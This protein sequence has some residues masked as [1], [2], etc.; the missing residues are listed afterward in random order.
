MSWAVGVVV[1]SLAIALPA[2]SL[3]ASGRGPS[4]VRTAGRPPGGVAT[5]TTS[6]ETSTSVTATTTIVARSTAGRPTTTTSLVCRDSIDPRC[7]PFYWDPAPALF[8]P[9]TVHVS[10][11]PTNPRPGEVVTFSFT[12]DDPV[13]PYIWG[14]YCGHD[15]GDQTVDPGN[16]CRGSALPGPPPPEPHGPWTPPPPM[17]G[18]CPASNNDNRVFPA[19]GC[20]F[21]PGGV[22][23]GVPNP[24][25]AYS[26]AGTY[27]ASF[28]FHA[29]GLPAPGS[30]NRSVAGLPD[31]YADTDS[32]TVA[33]TVSGPPVT[34]TSTSTS[35]P[36]STTTTVQ[37]TTTVG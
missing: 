18:H 11:L 32:V 33:V 27:T 8:Q 15:W 19:Q 6:G 22:S 16:T 2:V 25:H 4:T 37:T 28:I 12:A 17:A 29:F 9:L 23:G 34:T 3:T 1:V 20:Q 30:A 24:T 35:T 7:G 10:F 14:A 5:S 21:F 31:P 13:A 36:G 26:A